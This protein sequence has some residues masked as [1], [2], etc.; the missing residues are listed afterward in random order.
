MESVRSKNDA[1]NVA[2][3]LPQM[4]EGR[5]EQIALRI[6]A[7]ELSDGQIRYEDY[8]FA[9]LNREVDRRCHHLVRKGIVRGSRV[10][11]LVKPGLELT[12]LFFALFKIGAVPVLIDPGMG[13][14]GFLNCVRTSQPDALLAIPA[15][16]WVRRIFRKPFR[17]VKAVVPVRSGRMVETNGEP[18]PMAETGGDDLAAILFTSGSTGPAKGVCY[19]HRMFE[20]QVRMIR[21]AYKIEPGEVDLPML[22]VFALFNPA[23]GMTTVIPEMNPS[24]PATV[25]PAK[26]VRAIEQCG[27]TNSFGS[28]VLWTKIGRYCRENEIK[29]PTMKRILMAGAPV[30]PQLI[31]DFQKILPKGEIHT[32]YGATECLPV[33]SISGPE[34]LEEAESDRAVGR[35]T[36]V[37]KPLPEVDVKILPISD[38]PEDE[39]FLKRELPAGEIGEIV[40]RGPTVTEAY[41][42]LPEATKGAKI[43][44]ADGVWHRIGDLGY[45][46]EKGKLWFCGRQAER[47]ETDRGILFTDCC[48]SIFNQHRHVFRTALIGLG[49]WPAQTPAIVVEPEKGY[50]P[51]SAQQREKFVSELKELGKQSPAT[52]RIEN[53]FFHKNLPVDVRHNAKIHRRTLARMYSKF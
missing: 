36:C 23:L 24:R 49:D 32:P 35:G 16:I 53:F 7:G 29:F 12:A 27:V 22:P 37:G 8:S 18:F 48:E 38:K 15:G 19:K 28:P 3:F 11:V 9:E 13:L 47:V 44:A 41:D 14:R 4:A 43:I 30:S 6:P 21:S 40:V 46:D 1:V 26:I 51:R 2:R 20:A 45:F 31:R 17:S 50:F 25:D 52:T 39:E 34:I 33:T 10:L 5:G 42:R